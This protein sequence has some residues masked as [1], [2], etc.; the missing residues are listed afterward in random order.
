MA[1]KYGDGE[2]RK[3]GRER[4]RDFDSAFVARSQHT[5]PNHLFIFPC[6]VG[7]R[8]PFPIHCATVRLTVA[9]IFQLGESAK[10]ATIKSLY[11]GC[12]SFAYIYLLWSRGVVVVVVVWHI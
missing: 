4:E 3:T 1:N 8:V 9:D 2:D 6:D 10:S 12:R 5:A 7:L 11:S